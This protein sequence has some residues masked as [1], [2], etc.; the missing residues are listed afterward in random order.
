MTRAVA[1]FHIVSQGYAV[2]PYPYSM[3]NL[4]GGFVGGSDLYYRTG[5]THLRTARAFRTAISILIGCLRFHKSL[6]IG[7]GT[8]HIVGT[9]LYAQLAGRAMVGEVLYA[10]R[11]RRHY[12]DF[13]VRYLFILYHGESSVNFLFLGP[14]GGRSGSGEGG[15]NKCAATS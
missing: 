5:R 9:R 11:T 1:A 15:H 8:E 6:K 7:R 13:A 12:L 2:F 3:T 4:Y 10:E 14:E